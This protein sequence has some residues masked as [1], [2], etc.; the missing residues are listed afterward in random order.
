MSRTKKEEKPHYLALK[1]LVQKISELS[2]FS[3]GIKITS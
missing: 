1:P 2:I 3:Q